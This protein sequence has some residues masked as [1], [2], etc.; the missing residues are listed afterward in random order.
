MKNENGGTKGDVLLELDSRV[1]GCGRLASHVPLMT[2]SAAAQ[3]RHVA[4]NVSDDD[5]EEDE[6]VPSSVVTSLTNVDDSMGSYESLRH[7]NFGSG[8]PTGSESPPADRKLEY[9]RNNGVG[10]GRRSDSLTCGSLGLDFGGIGEF[11]LQ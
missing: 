8:R 10:K 1:P 4:T 5:E 3:R 6:Y 7:C 9:V 11:F 2:S